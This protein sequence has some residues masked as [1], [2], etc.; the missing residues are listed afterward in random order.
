MN[1]GQAWDDAGAILTLVALIPAA[2]IILIMSRNIGNPDFDMISAFEI[3][4]GV[5]VTAV[6]PALGATFILAV[7]IYAAHSS[8]R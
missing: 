4:I 1:F 6:I 7:I 8:S 3:G 2:F 5:I